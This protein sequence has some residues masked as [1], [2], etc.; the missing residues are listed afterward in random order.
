MNFLELF[1]EL[2]MKKLIRFAILANAAGT[3]YGWYYYHIQLASNPVYTWPVITDSPNSTLLFTIAV[4]LILKGKKSDFIS[5]LASSSL[6]KY[7]LWTCF[8]LLFHRSFF[9]SQGN[10]LLYTGIFITH[11]LMAVEAL[12]LAHTVRRRKVHLLALA[13]LLFN[14]FCDYGLGLHPYIPS[15]GIGIVASVTVSLTFFS[16]FLTWLIA[17]SCSFKIDSFKP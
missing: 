17:E 14:D 11:S 12:P 6:V 7:G 15:E 13:W 3:V 9:F 2:K 5:F 8:V 16:F 10:R 1:E 4:I